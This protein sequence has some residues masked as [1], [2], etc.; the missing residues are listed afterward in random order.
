MTKK[1]ED[2]RQN[3]S[4]PG[5]EYISTNLR[6]NKGLIHASNIV[7]KVNSATN[8]EKYQAR[9]DKLKKLIGIYTEYLTGQLAIKDEVLDFRTDALSDEQK[10]RINDNIKKRVK[11]LNDYYEK[12]TALKIEGDGDECYDSRSKIRS[13]ILEE[14]MFLLFREFV[15]SI[16][17]SGKKKLLKNG[18]TK[19]YS[20]MFFTASDIN[21]FVKNPSIQINTKNQDYAIYREVKI[22]LEGSDEAPRKASIPILAIEDKT[23]L[24]KTMLEGAIATAEK[25]KMGAPYSVFIVVAETYAVDSSVDPAYSRIDQIFVL[26]KCKD[27]ERGE[28]DINVDVVQNL[29]W[30]VVNR[31]MRPWF[32]IEKKLKNSG[33][34]I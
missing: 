32:D 16:S 9:E 25:I 29:F 22:L 2:K 7:A 23:Y 6:G 19:A 5:I 18:S 11:L 24:D 8:I 31:L 10:T 27:S 21:Q 34:I 20:N 4:F 26:R 15:G 14:F 13:T 3:D 33:T 30:F 28:N 12:F 17:G 1:K